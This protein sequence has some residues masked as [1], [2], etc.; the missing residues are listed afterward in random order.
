V[1]VFADHIAILMFVA[2]GVVIFT[3]L[4]VALALTGVGLAFGLAGYALGLV[5]PGDFGVIYHRV[6]GTLSD[7]EDIQWAAVPLLILMGAILQRSGIARE[8]LLSLQTLL[9]HVPGGL[10]MAVTLVGVVL[11]PTA[12]M[13]GASA[14]TLALIALP[15]MLEQGYRA[16]FASGT[17][18]AAG[19]LGVGLPPGIMLFFLA[20]AMGM[21]VPFIFLA[22]VGPALLLLGLYF[23]YYAGAC[24][25]WSTGSRVGFATARPVHAARFARNLAAPF[26]LVVMIL[27]SIIGGWASLSE[28]ATIG[29]LG[30]LL[31]TGLHGNLSLRLLHEA[32]VR[33]TVTTAMV[34][35]I[36]VGATTFSLIFRLVGGV[37]ALTTGLTGL[38]LGSWGTL[39]LV[40]LVVFV[41]GCFLDWLEIVLISFTILRPVLDALDFSAHIAR[42]Y[43]A[44]GW[45]TILVGLTLETS[46]LTPPFGYALF[47]VRGAAPSGVRMADLYR[48]IVPFVVIQLIVIVCVAAFPGIATWL[49]DQLLNL[50]AVR[51]VKA[52]E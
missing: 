31:F 29:A 12:G 36:F 2:L 46:F 50:H 18:A 39:A 3:G 22:M 17:I 34:F 23:A 43:V 15:T 45:I 21:Q 33:T 44:F 9:R 49:P 26:A 11:A 47:F 13:V 4:P 5:R 41:L 40:L 30:A 52:R 48:G 6:Y 25:L 32:V 51:G 42:P 27:G 1:S 38:G 28:A 16:P 24:S 10:P 37:D 8:S 14:A 20:D 7:S 19:A 35:F